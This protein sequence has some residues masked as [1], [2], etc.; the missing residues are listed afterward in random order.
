MKNVDT[1]TVQGFGEE[2][3]LLSQDRL[4]SLEA[5]Q[6]FD[7]YFKIFPWQ[8]L[9]A[10]AVGADLG[11][12]SGRWARLACKRVGHLF[13]CDASEKAIGVAKRNLSDEK[14]VSFRCVSVSDTGFEPESLDF[15]YSLGVLHHVPDA[16]DALRH[17]ALVLKPDAPLL[18]YLYYSFENRSRWFR[19]LW[20]VSDL[21]RRVI[22]R[23]PYKVRHAVT[24][25]LTV[26]IYWPLS[27][28]GR[29]LAYFDYMPKN[30][31][32]AYQI[33][34]S[35]YTLRTDCLDRFGTQLEKRYSREEIVTLLTNCG[36]GK[37]IFSDREPFWCV[38][39]QRN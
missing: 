22:S 23:L 31:P 38:V 10:G 4:D 29:F 6:I 35:F 28:T 8:N 13:L 15:A 26:V 18:L 20:R 12:G 1:K 34:K 5:A 33:D 2:W 14:N 27:R 3:S 25:L 16:T 19:W 17:I 9:R 37:I 24:F 30:W 11:C 7:D 36:F 32:L 21:M 39:C